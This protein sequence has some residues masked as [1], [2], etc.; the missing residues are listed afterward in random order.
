[1]RDDVLVA[2]PGGELP[3]IAAGAGGLQLLE[4]ARTSIGMGWCGGNGT[5]ALTVTLG[6]T[7]D[8]AAFCSVAEGKR[9]PGSSPG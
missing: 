5:H 8:P 1:M 7:R 2:E 3:A 9:D 4:M 6:L